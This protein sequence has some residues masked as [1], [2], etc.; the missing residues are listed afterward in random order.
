MNRRCARYI[1]TYASLG[2][3][4]DHPPKADESA[5]CTIMNF[6]KIIRM[7]KSAPSAVTLSEAKGLLRWA[8]RC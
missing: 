7:M 6:H 4:A 1:G 5:V 8:T 3:M 2:W